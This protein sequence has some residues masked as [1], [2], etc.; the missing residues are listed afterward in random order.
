MGGFD[1]FLQ[2]LDDENSWK[3]LDFVTGVVR[4]LDQLQNVLFR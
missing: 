2:H 1:Y 4:I 3:G